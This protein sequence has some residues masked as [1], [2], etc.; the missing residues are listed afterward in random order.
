MRSSRSAYAATYVQPS[1]QQQAPNGNYFVPIMGASPEVRGS[2]SILVPTLSGIMALRA[3][4]YEVGHASFF[5]ANN[6]AG[7]R[8]G[9]VQLPGNKF[10]AQM[11]VRGNENSSNGVS[12]RGSQV[13]RLGQNALVMLSLFQNSGAALNIAV[14]T[15]LWARWIGD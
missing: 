12:V 2:G 8:M 11:E 3:G 15:Y 4:E 13:V 1:P 9:R 14:E 10:V 5:W 7:T 6:G